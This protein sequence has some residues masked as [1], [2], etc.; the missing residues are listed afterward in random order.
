MDVD[1]TRTA[2]N[3]VDITIFTKNQTL[4]A[5]ICFTL[6]IFCVLDKS[7]RMKNFIWEKE[8][9]F[10]FYHGM[11]WRNFLHSTDLQF[12]LYREIKLKYFELFDNFWL[13]LAYYD[14]F[15]SFLI[16]SIV[17]MENKW[18]RLVWRAVP[19]ISTSAVNQR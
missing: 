4:K 7:M 5:S 9:F 18:W 15:F 1:T 8:Y 12:W 17:S 6:F 14:W 11:N 3:E 19:T 10:F 13:S 16:F 2:I